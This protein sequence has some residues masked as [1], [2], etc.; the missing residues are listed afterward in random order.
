MVGLRVFY[1]DEQGDGMTAETKKALR[2]ETI[3]VKEVCKMALQKLQHL[4]PDEVVPVTRTRAL[5]LSMNPYADPDDV[6]LLLAYCDELCIGYLSVVPCMLRTEE[7]LRK[8]YFLSQW[9]VAPEHR[10]SGAGALLLM[11]GMRL[12]HD[13]VMTGLSRDAERVFRSGPFK[14]FR[15]LEYY[16][17]FMDGLDVLGFPAFLAEKLLENQGRTSKLLHR[18]A[19]RKTKFLY[20]LVKRLVYGALNT[21]HRCIAPHVAIEEVD[22]LED[23]LDSL[24]DPEQAALF[25]RGPEAIHWMI[26]YPWYTENGVTAATGYFFGEHS[27]LFRYVVL[28]IK[29][30][31][32]NQPLGFVVFSVS[33]R[34][35]RVVMKTLDFRMAKPEHARYLITA[36]LHCASRY[37]ADR[38]FL[39]KECR[40]FLRSLLMMRW[41]TFR[42]K[43]ACFCRILQKDSALA[44]AIDDV[45]LHLADGDCAF[46]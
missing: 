32:N 25:H 4:H 26:S 36:A 5:S 17:V 9:Y 10:A 27:P 18:V 28:R 23:A 14:E 11:N 31:R 3:R 6:A 21:V 45:E 37:Q 41:L 1:A 22:S 34:T 38:I 43:R 24:P 12:D 35:S 29:D 20:P 15:P 13:L 46:S 33:N 19:V 40:P 30:T 2:I 39:P 44:T 16:M 8:V 7:E 42:R